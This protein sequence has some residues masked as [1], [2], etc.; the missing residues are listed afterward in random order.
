MPTV[1]AEDGYR[2][3]IYPNDHL[4]AHTHVQKAENEARIP[5][6]T[7]EV[8]SSEG[9]NNRELHKVVELVKKHQEALLSVVG[10]YH[11]SR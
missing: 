3:K 4:P 6:D 11:E 10:Y 1:A 2:L 5:L 7:L 9:F 8:V